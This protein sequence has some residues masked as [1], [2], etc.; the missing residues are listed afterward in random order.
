MC[1]LFTIDL[2]CWCSA[3]AFACKK[4]QPGSTCLVNGATVQR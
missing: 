1:N 4:A 3:T 2:G